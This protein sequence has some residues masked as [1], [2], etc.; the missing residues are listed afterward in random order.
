MKKIVASTLLASALF[1]DFSASNVQLLYSNHFTGNSFVYDA[2]DGKK[3]T[4]TLEHFRE[5]GY[6]D[7]FWFADITNGKS[8]E[9][10]ETMVYSEISPRLSL[11]KISGKN[12]SFGVIK[13]LFASGQYN[14]GKGYQAWLGGGGAELELPFMSVFGVNVYDKRQNVEGK[15]QTQTTINYQT[16]EVHGFHFT[17]FH[18]ITSEDYS[19]QNQLLYNIGRHFG[20]KR[21]FVGFEHLHYRHNNGQ[22]TDALQ[23]MLKWSW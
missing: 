9:G 5:F 2:K 15:H 21:L 19:T 23:T 8:F 13:D 6:G 16:I 11:S 1:A 10:Q 22:K 14:V 4:L 7:V 3:T 17:G 18:D 20:E 12:L